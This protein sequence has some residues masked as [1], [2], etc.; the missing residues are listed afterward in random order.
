MAS[1]NR[2]ASSADSRL[3]SE[4]PPEPSNILAQFAKHEIG[5]VATEI[6][7]RRILL[8]DRQVGGTVQT[9]IEQR[10]IGVL[11]V[12]VAI[13]QHELTHSNQIAVLQICARSRTTSSV[14]VGLRLADTVGETKRLPTVHVGGWQFLQ[15]LETL[16]ELISEDVLAPRRQR[17]LGGQ[18]HQH[19]RDAAAAPPP[20]RRRTRADIAQPARTSFLSR[21]ARLEFRG[22]AGDNP[23][24]HTERTHAVGRQRNLQQG[25]HTLLSRRRDRRAGKP[26]ACCGAI[27]DPHKQ[28]A[29]FR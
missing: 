22:K 28:V 18:H 15:D 1:A 9:R 21:H 27:G 24:R 25:R 5:S 23:L 17:G 11:T 10:P 16:R 26:M 7:S 3:A 19:F 4:E 20:A 6:P 2:L 29:T 14:P 8:C 13:P 12:F